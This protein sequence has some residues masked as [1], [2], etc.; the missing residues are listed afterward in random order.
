[1]GEPAPT[2]M[3]GPKPAPRKRSWYQKAEL[4]RHDVLMNTAS[5]AS[6]VLHVAFERLIA[7]WKLTIGIEASAHWLS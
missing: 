4:Y 5:Q 2:H 6:M 3:L 7:F 1:M